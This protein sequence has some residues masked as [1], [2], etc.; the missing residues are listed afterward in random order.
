VDPILTMREAWVDK[1]KLSHMFRG[2]GLRSP[3]NIKNNLAMAYW[4]LDCSQDA[5]ERGQLADV[6]VSLALANLRGLEYQIKSLLAGRADRKAPAPAPIEAA[7]YLDWQNYTFEWKDSKY[8]V[9][10]QFRTPM[11]ASPME[12]ALASGSNEFGFAPYWMKRDRQ[13]YKD[14]EVSNFPNG[15]DG[16]WF[17]DGGTIDNEPLGRTIDL[18]GDLD[19]PGA[20]DGHAF[21]R[22]HLLIHPFPTAPPPSTSM[23]WADSRLQPFWSQVLLRGL[24]QQRYQSLYADVLRAEKTNSR[25]LWTQDL[26]KLLSGLVPDD[27]VG[28]WRQALVE[29]A[30][31][32]EADKRELPRH[33][34]NAGGSPADLPTPREALTG[35]FWDALA[36]ASGLSEKNVI[37]VE[38]VSPTPLLGPNQTVSDLLAGELLGS[39]GGFVDVALRQ[40]DF[41]LGY[42]SMSYWLQDGLQRYGLDPSLDARARDAVAAGEEAVRRTTVERCG[43]QANLGS[44]TVGQEFWKNPLPLL[45][46]GFK[47]PVI[48][49][50]DAMRRLRGKN[51]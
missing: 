42:R 43:P 45:R 9:E 10:D 23:A 6:H 18:T 17:T 46:L 4:L 30:G 25:I 20:G 40:S 22:L 14:N 38:A 2:A 11:G 27:E 41:Y 16:F 37:G 32:V 33:R 31:G 44:V 51:V 3:L 24:A 12:Y 5:P 35:A 15:S 19:K 26:I 8:R 39:F 28:T 7:S 50:W 49:A 34:L 29:F 36:R 13:R 21:R 1:A 47:I 48:L